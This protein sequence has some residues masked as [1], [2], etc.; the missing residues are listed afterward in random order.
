MKQK[1]TDKLPHPDLVA[2]WI[3]TAAYIYYVL[4]ESVMLDSEYDA[5]SAYVADHWD[6]LHEDRKWALESPEAIRASGYHIKFSTQA[7]YSALAL[8]QE[9][10]KRVSPRYPE[11][12]SRLPNGV[13]YCT[14]GSK[15]VER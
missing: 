11:Q 4:D 15:F 13:L 3:I 1:E 5:W 9:K 7:Y 14:T 12:W 10:F 2:R 8:F 6:E